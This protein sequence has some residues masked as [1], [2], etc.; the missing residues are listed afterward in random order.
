MG[1]R[2]TVEYELKFEVGRRLHDKLRH[3]F[4]TKTVE[5]QREWIEHQ[6]EEYRVSLYRALEYNRLLHDNRRKN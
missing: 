1:P 3:L 4:L 5:E 6:Q 2:F